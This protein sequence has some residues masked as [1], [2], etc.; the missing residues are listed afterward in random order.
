MNLTGSTEQA[1]TNPNE[2]TI[3][4]NTKPKLLN[5]ITGVALLG[6]RC[7]VSLLRSFAFV[8]RRRWIGNPSPNAL[9]RWH[10]TTGA[11]PNS[12]STPHVQCHP[13]VLS[14][15]RPIWRGDVVLEV[16]GRSDVCTAARIR[17]LA[18]F[19]FGNEG[20]QGILRYVWQSSS[21]I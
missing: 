15:Q 1:G 6:H 10:P 17:E 18:I 9:S 13:R 2:Q 11:L 8:R 3:H 4:P 16:A 5:Q 19:G 12:P 21:S 20:A 14:Q 7:F